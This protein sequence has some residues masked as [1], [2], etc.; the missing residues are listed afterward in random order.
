MR[1]RDFRDEERAR[2]ED[3]VHADDRDSDR[4]EREGPVGSGWPDQCEEQGADGGTQGASDY[5]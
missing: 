4:R 5:G 1:Q 2:G 3:E